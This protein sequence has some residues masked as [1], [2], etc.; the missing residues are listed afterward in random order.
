MEKT[1]LRHRSPVNL[2]DCNLATSFGLVGDR[3]TLLIL[4]SALY[5]VR[6]FDDFRA[7]M[8]IPGT[9]LSERLKRLVG[10][11]MMTQREYQIPGRRAR[12]EYHLTEMGETLRLPFLAMTQWADN[13]LG[14]RHPPPLT[15]R[16]NLTGTAVDIGFVDAEG[17][18]VNPA[19]VDIHFADW[20]L[21]NAAGSSD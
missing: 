17:T 21:E 4:R 19:E 10:N 7:E 5:G 20:A 13:W 1:Q 9:V 16:R 8:G 11:G 3:W 18:A 2:A 12:S 15:L 14:S 6:R